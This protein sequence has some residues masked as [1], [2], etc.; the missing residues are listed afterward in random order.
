MHSYVLQYV[1]TFVI[2]DIRDYV[3]DKA[4]REPWIR[5]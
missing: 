2:R 1:L 3:A 4:K 5:D